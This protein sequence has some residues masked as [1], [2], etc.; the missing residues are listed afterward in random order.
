[1][2]ICA[3]GSSAIGCGDQAEFRNC[4]DVTILPL[5]TSGFLADP[6]SR[7]AIDA[8]ADDEE[9]NVA[10]SVDQLGDDVLSLDCGGQ[11]VI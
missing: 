11:W 3:D 1:M 5:V 10:I 7:S 6:L 2:G 9:T 8:L 4:A